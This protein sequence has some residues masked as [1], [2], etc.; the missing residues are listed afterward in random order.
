LKLTYIVVVS[1][2]LAA[3]IYGFTDEVTIEIKDTSPDVETI[4]S[5]TEHFRESLK[6]WYDRASVYT[7]VEWEKYCGPDEGSLLSA[8]EWEKES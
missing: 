5:M 2:E 3:G 7:G 6:E 8:D 1:P 4:Q